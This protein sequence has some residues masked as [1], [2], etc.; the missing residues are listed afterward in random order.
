MR[1]I[2]SLLTLSALVAS[3][4]SAQAQWGDLKVRFVVKGD[5]PKAAKLD[6]SKEPFCVKHSAELVDEGVV[7]GSDGGFK[8]VVVSLLAADK[9]VPVHPD[10]EAAA[11]GK[12][13][14]DNNHCRFEPR[15][16]AMRTSQTLT[17]KNSD[18]VGHNA[19]IDL[20][21][22]AAQNPL[23][24]AGGSVDLNF[25]KPESRPMP[26][27]CSIHPWMGGN[28]VIKDDPYVGVSDANGVVEIKN[29]PAGKWTFVVWHERPAYVTKAT[30][31]G[32]AQ[33]WKRGRVEVEI[34]NGK[35]A[36]LGGDEVVIEAVDLKKK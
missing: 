9:K 8:N 12:V 4:S 24:P 5:V 26:M 36:N 29:I 31:G 21:E 32:K 2:V 27:S 11:K 10:Y 28:I 33:A 3:A 19:K 16:V 25:G 35:V 7:V 34:V 6:V 20:F 13:T 18:P 22:N 15:V 1:W 30:V 17:V 23:I 14:V